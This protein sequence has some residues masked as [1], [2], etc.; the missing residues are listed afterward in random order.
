VIS[1]QAS[2][3]L[4]H[5]PATLGDPGPIAEDETGSSASLAGRAVR[6]PWWVV[7]V[8]A[9][10]GLAF[11][12]IQIMEKIALL[13][14]PASGLFCDINA[15]VSCTNV[16][17]AW[18]SSV[19]GPPNALIGAIMFALLGSAAL[20]GVLGSRPSRAYLLVLWGL[21]LFFAA[22][23]T[24][25]MVQTAFVIGSLCLWCTGIVTSVLA[26]C[27]ALTRLAHRAGAFGGDGFGRAMGTV[28]RSGLDLIIVVG[29]WLAIAAMLV[30]G[31]A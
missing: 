20:G 12:T 14:D 8:A 1:T 10:A 11:T 6:G 18:Q 25:F 2:H 19:L 3:R 7:L 17:N 24:W 23:A 15:T 28:V 16:L 4:G 31:L 21:A 13:K 22:F 26:S 29:W 30:L 27:A 9:A 5:E